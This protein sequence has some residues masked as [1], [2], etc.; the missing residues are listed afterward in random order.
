MLESLQGV[1]TAQSG[2]SYFM[3]YGCSECYKILKL[4]SDEYVDPKKLP[5]ICPNCGAKMD[6]VE[7]PIS[8][9]EWKKIGLCICKG[10]LEVNND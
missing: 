9:E 3:G 2:E 4:Y 8:R 10:D 7:N 5:N 1:F 6:G